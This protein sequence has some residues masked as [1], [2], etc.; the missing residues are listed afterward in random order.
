MET[1]NEIYGVYLRL[2]D[3]LCKKMVGDEDER[4]DFNFEETMLLRKAVISL[5]DR[6]FGENSFYTYNDK[7][8]RG[9]K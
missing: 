5:F 3:A 8:K 9:E 7:M 4:L 6:K 2:Q 1:K